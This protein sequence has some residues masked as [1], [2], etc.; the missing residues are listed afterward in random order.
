MIYL[1]CQLS[2]TKFLMANF[3]KTYKISLPKDQRF[4]AIQLQIVEIYTYP[5]L[6]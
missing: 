5:S 3:Q 4:Q 6:D 2:R 1:G